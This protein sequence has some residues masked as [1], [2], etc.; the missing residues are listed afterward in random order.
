MLL[1]LLMGVTLQAAIPDQAPAIAALPRA[2]IDLPSADADRDTY[3]DDVD[4]VA[5]DAMIRIQ[6]DAL[7]APGAQPYI[8]VGTQDDHWRLGRGA[9]LKWPHIVDMDPL[10]H[11]VGSP[12]WAKQSIRTGAWWMSLPADGASKSIGHDVLEPATQI[13][14]VEWP[15]TFWVNVRD[16][17]P[18]A[19]IDLSLWNARPDPDRR[20]GAWKLDV[21]IRDASVDGLGDGWLD[22][23]L[24]IEVTATTD[25]AMETKQDLADRWA[26]TIRFAEGE[27]FFPLPGDIMERFH[28]IASREPDHR[29]WTRDF[30]NARDTYLL[31]LAD[32]NGDRITNHEDAAVMVDLLRAGGQ[33][34]PTIYSHVTQTTGDHV[35]IQYWL[36]YAYN[37]VQDT[38]G[39]DV[40]FLAHNGDRELVQLRFASLEDALAGR[41]IDLTYSQHYKGIRF[42]DPGPG[43]APFTNETHFDIYVA[44]GSHASYPLPGDD[45]RLRPAFAGYGDRFDGLGEVW[46][47][48][49]YTVEILSDQSFHAGYLWG[50]ITRHHRDLGSAGKP[51]LQHTFR[52]PFLDPMLWQHN[53]PFSEADGL[54][55]LYGGA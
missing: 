42:P 14:G 54:A 1:A 24:H 46:T 28:G 26:P 4:L 51:L 11:D 17:R 6:I 12:T 25:L 33:A 8:V 3:G 35:V 36:L 41:P 7:Q 9:E 27:R 38:G 15:Q 44:R 39:E 29:T 49:N 21:D 10:G 45:R 5:G 16:D 48:G 30:N 13:P 31:Y 32:F 55:A 50:P 18:V 43:T 40:Q 23:L 52:Y 20:L 22:D 2:P 47:P 53:R 37:Y 19:T 34:P